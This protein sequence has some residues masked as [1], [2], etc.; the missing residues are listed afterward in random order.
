[1]SD[2][3]SKPLLLGM[4]AFLIISEACTVVV[5]N[6]WAAT[7]TPPIQNTPDLEATVSAQLTLEAPTF[8][9]VIS[10]PQPI[11]PTIEIQ[12]PHTPTTE[13]VT[14]ATSEPDQMT[15]PTSG[16]TGQFVTITDASGYI[17]IDVPID[18]TDVD[19]GMAYYTVKEGTVVID[20]ISA[21]SIQ[22]SVDLKR[23]NR[24]Y[25]DLTEETKYYSPGIRFSVSDKLAARY[26]VINFL[27]LR[28]NYPDDAELRKCRKEPNPDGKPYFKDYDDIKIGGVSIESAYSLWKNC[29]AFGGPWV[30][31]FVAKPQNI[32]PNILWLVEIQT[33][34]GIDRETVQNLM[35]RI[36][37]SIRILRTF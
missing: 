1:M 4:I 14:P 29:G 35:E 6:P 28:D 36:I 19:T 31:V 15:S 16:V 12:I 32:K 13:P 26:G 27:D 8:M 7:N 20:K 21:P 3:F 22:A 17:Q 10:T 30:V 2:R 25:S 11:E 24:M 18:W 5:R 9:P 33:P 34:E 37:K 23:F